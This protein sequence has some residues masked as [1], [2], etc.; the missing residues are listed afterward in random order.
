MTTV[1]RK[2]RTQADVLAEVRRLAPAIGRRAGEVEAGRRVPRDLL[3]GLAAAGVFR[4]LRPAGHG[5]LAADLPGALRVYEELARADASVGWIAAL[6]SASWRDLAGLP[7]TG[8]DE[9]FAGA[10]D[11]ITAGV[12][13]PTGA[14]GPA[15]GGYRVSG[16]W[17]FAS[18]CEHADWVYG[19]C[20]EGV[21]DGVPR[22]RIAVFDPRDVVVEDTWRASGLCGTA[23]HHFHV[24]D[25]FVPSERTLD[26]MGDAPS[27]DAPVVR[28]PPPALFALAIA[29]VAIGC[30]QGALDD[31]LALAAHKVPLLRHRP[32]AADPTFQHDLA[33]ADTELAAARAL[34]GG[35]A[36][37]AQAA[38]DA[39]RE[40]TP[41]ERAR[42]RAAAAW[43]AARAADVTRCAY[44]AGGGGAVLAA[45]PLQRRLRDVDA[46]GQHFLVRRDT[47]TTAG[48]LLA[49]EDVDV[50]V[51]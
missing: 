39:R 46:M 27:V 10:P 51:F 9:L 32:L 40:P 47:M 22:L 50:M 4:L 21:R 33:A 17:S 16:R 13:S 35:S 20:V 14:I 38:A 43:A 11:A 41:R 28:V 44:R 26:P 45:S 49:G 6:G 5:G 48:A 36:A 18:G 15:D 29:S 30:A 25:V 31:I 2:T 34:V 24:D 1:D 8:F 37:V 23:S 19:N 3:D 12:F 7:R 42:V